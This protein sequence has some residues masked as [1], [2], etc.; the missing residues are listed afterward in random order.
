MKR[1]ECPICGGLLEHIEEGYL[2]IVQCEDCLLA[3]Q[4]AITEDE[5]WLNAKNLLAD[6]PRLM[7]L[8]I[9]DKVKVEHCGDQLFTV[10]SKNT[11]TNKVYFKEIIVGFP[12]SVY[13]DQISKWP[14]ELE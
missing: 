10:E 8:R 13:A 2:H 4:G 7:R 1:L 5:A 14:W 3:A 6:F 9:G 11:E 12:D